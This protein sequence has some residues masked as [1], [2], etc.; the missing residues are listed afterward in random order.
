MEMG[1]QGNGPRCYPISEGFRRLGVRATKG[2]G[3]VSSGE[4]QTFCIGRF[5]Y[6]TEAELDRFIAARLA[7]ALEESPEKRARKVAKAV[8]ARWQKVAG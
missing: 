3:L 8:G 5:R 7:E 4:L 1:S 2:W 6:V